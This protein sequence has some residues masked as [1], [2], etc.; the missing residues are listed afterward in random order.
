[1]FW[2]WKYFCLC[3]VYFVHRWRKS[4]TNKIRLDWVFGKCSESCWFAFSN[5]FIYACKIGQKIA[6][7]LETLPQEET[8]TTGKVIIQFL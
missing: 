2:N 5:P 8:E 1:M 6:H 4:F 3:V 7:I